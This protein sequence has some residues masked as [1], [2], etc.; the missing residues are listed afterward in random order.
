[1]LNGYQ[2]IVG[3]TQVPDIMKVE[4]TDKS[5]TYIDVLEKQTMFLELDLPS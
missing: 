4:F 3:H 5:V 2:Q 1:M